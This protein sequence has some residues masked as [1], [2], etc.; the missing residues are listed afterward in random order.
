MTNKAGLILKLFCFWLICQNIVIFNFS[1]QLYFPL[2]FLLWKNVKAWFQGLTSILNHARIP[3]PLKEIVVDS[4]LIGKKFLN[5]VHWT[6]E[7][8]GS[9]KDT[10]S[11]EHSVSVVKM[12]QEIATIISLT[13]SN[14]A[15]FSCWFLV[16]N[17]NW[18]YPIGGSRGAPPARA[19]LS[20]QILS[21][22]HT[23]FP[24]RHHV[25]PGRPLPGWR[26]PSG[27]PGS[28]TVSHVLHRM[29]NVKSPSRKLKV[30]YFQIYACSSTQ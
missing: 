5:N 12:S 8:H 19:P 1:K 13:D 30:I 10:N 6:P 9:S 14:G 27:N 25:R 23:N 29:I 3:L 15:M 22:L 16:F 26:P 28:A 4:Y 17:N 7:H 2:I 20:V 18:L 24:Q 11:G 21:F